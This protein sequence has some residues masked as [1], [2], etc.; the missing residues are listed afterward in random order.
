MLVSFALYLAQLAF[1]WHLIT[2]LFKYDGLFL[3][4]FF[5]AVA[6]SSVSI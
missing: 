1:K 2:R 6:K 5:F 4:V 3:L